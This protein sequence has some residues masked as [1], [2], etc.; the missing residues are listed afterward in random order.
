MF[1]PQIKIYHY[2]CFSLNPEILFLILFIF[3][4]WGFGDIENPN[5]LKCNCCGVNNVSLKL[6]K[7]I[8]GLNAEIFITCGY[9]CLRN[10]RRVGGSNNSLHLNGTAIDIDIYQ[11]GYNSNKNR[12]KLTKIISKNK[13]LTVVQEVD[14]LH[15]QL[16]TGT[17][18][19]WLK[20]P[21]YKQK[22]LSVFSKSFFSLLNYDHNGEYYL[23]FK[24][25]RVK[26]FPDYT[27]PITL[28]KKT[29]YFSYNT[30]V[31]LVRIG[32]EYI[33]SNLNLFPHLGY[34]IGLE[35]SSESSNFNINNVYF[36]GDII[37][38]FTIFPNLNFIIHY[39]F[40][41]DGKL[42]FP[43]KAQY[44]FEFFKNI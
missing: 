34:G 4:Q 24:I 40:V 23:S 8:D 15:V 25:G 30:P 10:N 29:V 44:G 18:E 35:F 39:P 31:E 17:K 3:F 41:K 33:Y 37:I 21:E 36:A 22:K 11:N 42:N 19:R 9:R 2:P 27:H 1:K 6:I 20:T 13:K 38:D 28:M 26:Y 7:E 32:R 5:K 12:F 43:Y 14:H 16:N